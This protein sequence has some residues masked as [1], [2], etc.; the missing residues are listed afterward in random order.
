MQEYDTPIFKSI[1]K[2]YIAL[3]LPTDL[4]ESK[5]NFPNAKS[6]LAPKSL[7]GKKKIQKTGRKALEK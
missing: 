2:Y 4:K 1:F 5:P 3:N 7:S 6:A